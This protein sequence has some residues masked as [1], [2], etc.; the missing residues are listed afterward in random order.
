VPNGEKLDRRE[1][2]LRSVMAVLGGATITLG[3]CAADAPTQPTTYADQP[4]NV[5]SNH[6]HAVAIT[7]AQLAAGGGVV[8]DIQ[9]T[10][11]HPHQVELT[12][13][14]VRAIGEGRRV[15]KDSTPSPSGSHAH[16][17]T[18]N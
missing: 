13:A 6:G 15:A 16:T 12:A 8:L 9:G 14:E 11:S 2:T 1:F 10:A 18:F 7:G 4:G 5:V 17:V 3:G